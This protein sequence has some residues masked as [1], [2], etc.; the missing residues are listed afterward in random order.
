MEPTAPTVPESSAHIDM[1]L[2]AIGVVSGI[3]AAMMMDTFS[4]FMQAYDD[5]GREAP[6]AT[7]GRERDARG[8]QP[9][10]AEGSAEQ[11]ATVKVGTA[12]FRIGRR[13][14][15][16]TGDPAVAGHRGALRLQRGRR[17]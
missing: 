4:R 7:R 6:G 3:V 12:A 13:L 1:K 15:A 5:G 14:H 8:T 2:A 10:Q 11:D 16:G 17:A 9:A